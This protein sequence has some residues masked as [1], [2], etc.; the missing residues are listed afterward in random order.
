MRGVL[1]VLFEYGDKTMN[2]RTKL[3][4]AKKL[5]KIKGDTEKQVSEILSPE[6]LASWQAMKEEA[7]ASASN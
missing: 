5:K 2:T 1:G 6:Q 4:I 3:K 7:K